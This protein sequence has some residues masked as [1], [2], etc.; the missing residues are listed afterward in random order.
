MQQVAWE[1]SLVLMA[2]VGIVFLW[3][4]ARSGGAPVDAATVS[5]RGYRWR[6]PLVWVALVAGVV[7]AIGTLRHW[8]LPA[9]ARDAGAPDVV[10]Q[11]TA[12]QWSWD[13]VPDTVPAGKTVEFQLH[14]TDVNHGFALYRDAT[15]VVAQAQVMPGYVNRLRVRFDQPGEYQVLCLEYCGIA[16]ANMRAVV[17]V[18]AGS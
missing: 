18:V 10:V 7:I 4:C 6:G 11:A 13:I 5:A 14:S 16:H 2:L 8:P 12:R 1:L 3:V 15:H 9:Y 17:K